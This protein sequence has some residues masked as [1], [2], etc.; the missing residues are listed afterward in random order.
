MKPETPDLSPLLVA[1]ALVFTPAFAVA[2]ETL[3]IHFFEND[4]QGDGQCNPLVQYDF[5]TDVENPGISITY[6]L[7]SQTLQV[8]PILKKGADQKGYVSR[9]KTA[10]EVRCG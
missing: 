3:T 10:V 7:D 1:V 5:V 6:V 9:K 4:N 2:S 8:Q